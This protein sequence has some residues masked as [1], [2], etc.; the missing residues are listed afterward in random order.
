MGRH[1]KI[2]V[3]AG[4]WEKI[5]NIL[6]VAFIAVSAVY[7]IQA[8][9]SLPETIPTHFNGMG[10]ADDWGSKNTIFIMPVIAI[11]LF[12]PMYFL[13]KAP[14]LFNFPFEITE[15][16]AP[17]IYP[18]ARLLLAVFNFEMVA[19]FA[20]LAWET[21]QSAQSGTSLGVWFIVVVTIVPLIT[22]VFFLVRLNRLQ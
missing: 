15:E 9:G 12:V 14:H 8:W 6:S 22:I 5:L 20:F 13:C 21:I 11:V 18:V 3:P 1:P 19:L 2:K 7:V 4:K 17:R 10:E 16:N